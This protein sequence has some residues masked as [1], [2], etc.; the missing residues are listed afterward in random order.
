MP[1][2][3]EFVVDSFDRM[4]GGE[5]YVPRI[6]SMRIVDLAEAIAPG[7]EPYEIGIRPGEKLHEEMISA[8]DARRTSATTTATSSSR[9]VAREWWFTRAGRASP[10]PRRLL[11]PLRHQRPVAHRRRRLRA[12]VEP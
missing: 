1:Q 3:V 9:P 5:L 11:L 10:V 8:D 6:P 2:A 7:A 12:L 4:N